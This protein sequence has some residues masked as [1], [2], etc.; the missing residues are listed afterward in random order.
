[1]KAF[2][3]ILMAMVGCSCGDIIDHRTKTPSPVKTWKV[4]A[5]TN[6]HVDTLR[7]LAAVAPIN[8]NITYTEPTKGTFTLD[9]SGLATTITDLDT[10]SLGTVALDTV[11]INRLKICGVGEDEKC[12]SALIRIYT[13]GAHAGFINTT[14]GYGV[15]FT[16]DTV[17]VGLDAA[18]AIALDS[19]TIPASDRKLRNNDFTDTSWDLSIDMGNAEAGDYEIDIVIEF[20]LGN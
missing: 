13:T 1:M 7:G 8:T 14:E 20:L 10:I 19:Y 2:I 17:S 6:I 9:T 18:G 3:L 16:A 11:N 4:I 12:T 15:P 5:T